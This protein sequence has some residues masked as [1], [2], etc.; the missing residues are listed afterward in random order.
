[1]CYGLA[2]SQSAAPQPPVR[3]TSAT[4]GAGGYVDPD[5]Q[6]TDSVERYDPYA[7]AP[8]DVVEPPASLWT[9]LFKIG[10]G[11][12][13]AGSI[14]GSGELLLTTALGAKYGF[15]FLWLVLFSC[16]IKVFV[17]IEIGRYAISSAKP[18]LGALNELPGPRWRVH[19]MVWWW[20]F[21][22]LTTV[23]QLGGMVGGVGQALNLAFP[24]ASPRL[25]AA[26]TGS[27]PAL[28]GV[29][30]R[31][32]DYPW[33]VLTALAAIGLLRV[34]GYSVIQ[35]VTTVLVVFVTLVTV[36]CVAGLPSTG[37]PISIGDLREGFTLA[38]PAAG[39]AAAFGA[40]GITG[41][42]ASELFSYPYWCLEKGYARYVGRR[43]DDP[44]W[45]ARAKGW[46]RVMYLDAWVSMVVFTV[47]TVAFYCLGATVLHRQGLH[48]EGKQMIA[49]LSE[50][51]VPTFGDWTRV[52]FLIGAW[53]VLFKTLY[54]ASASHSRL[55]SDLL[56]LGRFVTYDGPDDRRR[57]I[58]RFCIFFP[59]LALTLYLLFPDP[60]GL[61]IVGG[62]AQAATLPLICGATLYLR[63]RRTD[64]RL[65]PSKLWDALLIVASLSISLVAV[66]AIWVAIGQLWGY[67]N[68]A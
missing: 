67:M 9:A 24:A 22:T 58:R 3:P 18:T 31:N 26:V 17:Q 61:V 63:Y 10:P 15:V 19:W 8:G 14:I 46:I 29:I 49:T 11:I 43:S 4:A 1:M 53:A 28:A 62:F 51:Y 32:P 54:V 12:I 41:V 59:C 39:I 35:R 21:M 33:A 56:N 68:S 47:A 45:A 65:A 42:G 64:P 6:H 2:M 7:M 16:V 23:T 37:Y 57:M 13:L 27:A 30:E 25:A 34:G 52:A 44:S 36:V 50:M 38:I 55:T 5:P 40:F 66:Y 48:P 60:K 20:L